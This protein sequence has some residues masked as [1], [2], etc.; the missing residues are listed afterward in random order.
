[1]N[2]LEQN[3]M[4]S[5]RI[6]KSDIIKLQQQS[7]ELSETQER[8]MEMLDELNVKISAL[9]SKNKELSFKVAKPVTK[10]IV[11]RVK[12]RP[13]VIVKRVKSKPKVIVKKIHTRPKTIVKTV[14]KYAKKRYVASKEG[15][16]F[17]IP[18]CPF[19]QNIKPKSKRVFKSKAAALNKGYKACKCVK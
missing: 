11:K 13:K 4:N 6:A 10:T 2:Q 7:V 8:M 14:T 16:D 15:K 3:I 12:T 1:M 17:H 18:K 9:Y 19:A 5:F